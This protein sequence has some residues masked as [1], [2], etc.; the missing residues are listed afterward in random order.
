MDLIL[1][2]KRLELLHT[3]IE[4][5][6]PK[7]LETTEIV[8]Y[9]KIRLAARLNLPHTNFDS[10]LYDDLVLQAFRGRSESLQD[11]CERWGS[12]ILNETSSPDQQ[13]A[14]F[15]DHPIWAAHIQSLHKDAFERNRN[16]TISQL[17]ELEKLKESSLI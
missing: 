3:L 17:E 5:E 15:S 14:L 10:M 11:T 1:A 9:A 12:E 7:H 8:I 4:K 16:V 2:G 13:A 6:F